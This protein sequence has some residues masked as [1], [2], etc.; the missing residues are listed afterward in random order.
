MF[1]SVKEFLPVLQSTSLFKGI[2]TADLESMLGCISVAIKTVRKGAII[3][4]A[5][6]TPR[7][8]GIVLRG[9]LHIIREDFD[10]NCSLLAVLTRGDVFAEAMCCA[11]VTES[12]V[13]VIADLDSAVILMSFEKILHICPS[14]C[15]YHRALIKNML[16]LIAG[17]NLKLQNHMEILGMKSIR[18]RVMRYFESFA[19]KHG[20]EITIPLNREELANYLCVE[21]SA[22]S[23]ELMKMKNDGLIEYRKNKFVLK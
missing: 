10:G 3:L 11:G 8:V 13:T 19:P 15:S 7:Q 22:L 21:R 4:H 18:A 14:S 23:H 12:P 1:V 16:E 20:I 17:K 6:D 9:Q 5:G 2:N